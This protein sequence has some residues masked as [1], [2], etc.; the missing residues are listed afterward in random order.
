MNRI[1]QRRTRNWRK[2][3][4][5]SVDWKEFW[6]WRKQPVKIIIPDPH[7][8]ACTETGMIK[9]SAVSDPTKWSS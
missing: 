4:T 9:F 8:W 6:E 1:A 7:F 2:P 5:Q 3:F